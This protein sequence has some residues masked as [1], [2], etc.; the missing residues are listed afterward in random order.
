MVAMWAETVLYGVYLVTFIHTTQVTFW[1]E[2]KL[3]KPKNIALAIVTIVFLVL[4]TFEVASNFHYNLLAFISY[5]GPGGLDAIFAGI[6]YWPNVALYTC[7]QSTEL[8]TD[9]MLIYRCLVI[10]Y[11]DYRIIIAPVILWLAN[12]GLSVVIILFTATL[13][14]N[15]LLYGTN[16]KPLITAFLA[17]SLGSNFITTGLIAYRISLVKR[18]MTGHNAKNALPAERAIKII[19]ESGVINAISVLVTFITILINNNALYI[20]ADAGKMIHSITFNL[21]IIRVAAGTVDAQ[22]CSPSNTPAHSDPVYPLH[23][24]GHSVRR[25]NSDTQVGVMVHIETIQDCSGSFKDTSMHL[26]NVARDIEEGSMMES[27]KN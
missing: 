21:I 13:H 6:S 18:R 3:S 11:Y 16:T 24:N 26:G 1:R 7:T 2:G 27:E 20:S 17:L 4:T 8:L 25:L 19:V 10:Y 9:A 22:T 14:S 15:A 5:Q 12:L 23:L